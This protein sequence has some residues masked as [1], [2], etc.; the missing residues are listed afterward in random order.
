MTDLFIAP[1]NENG[2]GNGNGEEDIF[3]PAIGVGIGMS[4]VLLNYALPGAAVECA[5]PEDT[6]MDDNVKFIIDDNGD[7]LVDD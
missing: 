1:D 5:G 4:S 6:I 3:V 7:C 2:D